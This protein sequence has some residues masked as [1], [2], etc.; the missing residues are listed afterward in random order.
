MRQRDKGTLWCVLLPIRWSCGSSHTHKQACRNEHA[1]THCTGMIIECTRYRSE[2]FLPLT[3][4]HTHKCNSAILFLPQVPPPSS[5]HPT[6]LQS[7]LPRSLIHVPLIWSPVSFSF[8]SPPLPPPLPASFSSLTMRSFYLSVIPLLPPQSI[9]PHHP[10]NHHRFAPL[11][12][13]SLPP[14]PSPPLPP[15]VFWVLIS[16][17]SGQEIITVRPS[18][19]SQSRCSPVTVV[20]F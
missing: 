20:S 11:P 2:L 14:P 6:L 10:L 19:S 17:G 13:S 1:H 16:F 15:Q 18:S 7:S 9:H 4:A 12:S 8:L 3:H 5:W